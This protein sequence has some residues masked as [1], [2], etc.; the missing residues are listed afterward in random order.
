MRTLERD[1]LVQREIYAS[2]PARVECCL[3]PPRRE[4]VATVISIR[5]WAG[6]HMALIESARA[7]FDSRTG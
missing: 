1:G 6:D 3:A 2:G 4:P 7:E 5:M